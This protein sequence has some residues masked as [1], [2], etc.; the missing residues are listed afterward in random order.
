VTIQD[1]DIWDFVDGKVIILT[2]VARGLGMEYKNHLWL[3]ETEAREILSTLE[4]KG[5]K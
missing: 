2:S 3:K 1:S 4:E 5:G